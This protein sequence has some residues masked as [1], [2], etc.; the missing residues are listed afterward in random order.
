MSN[1]ISA[2]RTR[3]TPGL[4]L[5]L[6]LHGGLAA[7]VG[8]SL[9][10][11]ARDARAE[12]VEWSIEVEPPPEL[13]ALAAA[14]APAPEA[15]APPRMRASAPRPAAPRSGPR[16][17]SHER[18]ALASL[19]AAP[20]S[21]PAPARAPEPAASAVAP[22]AVTPARAP[23]AAPASAASGP[24]AASDVSERPRLLGQPTLRYPPRALRLGIN[25][26]V[27]LTL[28][29]EPSGSVSAA[30]ILRPAGNGFDEAALDAAQRLRFAPGRVQ[31][32]AV[33]VRVTWTCRFRANG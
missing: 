20:S 26:D 22:A 32:S 8:V 9:A 14:L 3:A 23:S 11:P 33:A 6:L 1:S 19:R 5:S 2:R 27:V 24:Y 21:S 13:P 4:L 17:P 10:P 7:G 12:S 28:I 31:G 30:R 16:E 25:A 29:V 18:G 15:A